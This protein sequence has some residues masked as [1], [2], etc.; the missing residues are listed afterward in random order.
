MPN[1]ELSSMTAKYLGRSSPDHAAAVR[2]WLSS[3]IMVRE[4]DH[5]CLL[6]GADVL[7]LYILSTV[8]IIV[9]RLAI[10]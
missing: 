1:P 6:E 8:N 7:Y 2:R 9:L 10:T 5:R 4:C 3:G